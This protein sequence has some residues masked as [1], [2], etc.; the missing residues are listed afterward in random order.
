ML[1]FLSVN[2]LPRNFHIFKSLLPF[3]DLQESQT[4]DDLEFNV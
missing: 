1:L 4:S 2:I 3:D